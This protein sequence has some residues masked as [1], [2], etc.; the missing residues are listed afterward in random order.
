MYLKRK[1]DPTRGREGQRLEIEGIDTVVEPRRNYPQGWLASQVLGTVGTDNC[2]LRGLEQ[3]QEEALHGEDGKR[4]VVKDALGKP[5]S[6]VDVERAEPG[7]DLQLTIDSAI[8]ERVEAVL[9]EVGQTYRPKGAT[10]VVLDPRNG[11]ILA[12]ANWPRVDANDIGGRARVR[13]PEPR[14]RRPATSRARR[15]RRSPWPARMEEGLVTPRTPF[16]IR[17]T[18]QVAD[19]TIKEA[20]MAA[21]AR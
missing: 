6:I 17:P 8:Q 15:S 4:R 2:G 11:E 18:I 14:G 16:T 10:A 13:A 21:A 7:E 19:R 12:L 3:S 9:A 20:P 5:V 1:L